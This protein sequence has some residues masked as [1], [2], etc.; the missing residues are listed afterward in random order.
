MLPAGSGLPSA[1]LVA[2]DNKTGEVRAMVGGA[3]YATS[4]FNL[5]TQG[6]RQPGSTFKP[7]V[8][9]T[10]LLSGISPGSVWSSQPKQFVVPH[11]GGERVLRG[12]TTTTT[13]TAG[14]QTLASATTTSD[15]SVYAEVGVKVGTQQD[16]ARGATASASA[17]RSRRNYAMI[18]GG[19]RARR[20]AARH[21]ARVR[22]VRD[23]AASASGTRSWARRD[24]GPVGI[25]LVRDGD[26][27]VAD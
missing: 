15:N 14:S 4:P 7:F 12:Q 17:R 26:G 25:H 1:S 19:L 6:Q 11:S 16:R 3:D 20:H 21:G 23:R 2:I 8:L 9:T 18:L 10:A 24:K 5:A 22:D 27:K 13:P